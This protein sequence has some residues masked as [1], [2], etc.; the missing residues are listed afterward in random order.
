MS[1][2]SESL[3]DFASAGR[4]KKC[5]P[6]H[7]FFV[8]SN[9]T[10]FQRSWQHVRGRVISRPRSGGILSRVLTHRE[11]S[12]RRPDCL[13]DEPVNGEPV[14]EANS[15]RSGIRTGKFQI[16]ARFGQNPPT[17][18]TIFQVLAEKFPRQQNREL[19]TRNRERF[20][21]EQGAP[22]DR[23]GP[24]Q[25]SRRARALSQDGLAS[26]DGIKRIRREGG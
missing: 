20:A 16:L 7:P 13:A 12:P 24:N 15:L 4:S 3:S 10:L 8:G 2:S 6:R 9:D 19:N 26:S 18:H 11:I 17:K 1:V 21:E 22:I 25:A 23:S 14:C 5:I